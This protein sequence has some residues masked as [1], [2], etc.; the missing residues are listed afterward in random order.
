[1]ERQ[2]TLEDARVGCQDAELLQPAHELHGVGLERDAGLAAG[3]PRPVLADDVAIDEVEPVVAA[4]LGRVVAGVGVVVR[5]CTLAARVL[6]PVF[7]YDESG[8]AQRRVPLDERDREVDVELAQ[9]QLAVEVEH[10]RPRLLGPDQ[11]AVERPR[12]RVGQRR[13]EHVIRH[14]IAGADIGLEA[15]VDEQPGVLAEDVRHPGHDVAAVVA[16]VAVAVAGADVGLDAVDVGGVLGDRVG[17]AEVG[18]GAPQDAARAGDQLDSLDGLDRL[19]PRDAG[20]VDHSGRTSTRR[21]S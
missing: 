6:G 5:I 14:L 21:S 13:R 9:R 10:E 17:D 7:L 3:Q 16:A 20:D 15:G 19:H 12:V 18:V 4:L 1:M 2:A 11:G 8:E